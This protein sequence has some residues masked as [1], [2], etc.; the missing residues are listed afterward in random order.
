MQ[1]KKVERQKYA[2]NREKPERLEG[3]E[4]SEVTGQT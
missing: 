2:R 3:S 4:I 1:G